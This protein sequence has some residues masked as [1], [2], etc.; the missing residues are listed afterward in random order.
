MAQATFYKFTLSGRKSVLIHDPKKILKT[1]EQE[2]AI[3]E[4]AV[5]SVG[6]ENYDFTLPKSRAHTVR[7]KL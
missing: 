2:L 6:I 3:K 4:K 7:A 1:Y 5:N